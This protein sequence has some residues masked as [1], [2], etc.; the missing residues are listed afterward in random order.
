MMMD[1]M[2]YA[3]TV[4]LMIV[5]CRSVSANMVYAVGQRLVQGTVRGD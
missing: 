1:V 3:M 2:L 5:W 4:G